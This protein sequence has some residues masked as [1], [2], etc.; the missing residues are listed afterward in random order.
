M[1]QG[2]RCQ[3]KKME[4]EGRRDEERTVIRCWGRDNTPDKGVGGGG[5]QD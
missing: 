1:K 4:K 5:G 2:S 3:E